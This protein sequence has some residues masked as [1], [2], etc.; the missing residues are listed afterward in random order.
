[1]EKAC[2]SK[3]FSPAD[4]QKLNY[5]QLYLKV[6]TLSG[7][8]N[9]T[10]NSFT[11]G[12]LAGAES[13]SRTLPKVG[14]QSKIVPATQPGPFGGVPS[15]SM[16]TRTACSTL[17]LHGM[18]LAQIS[19]A[20]GRPCTHKNTDRFTD[21]HT[22]TMTPSNPCDMAISPSR[23]MIAMWMSCLTLFLLMRPRPLTAGTALLLCRHFIH[24]KPS[25][26]PICSATRS[27]YFLIMMLCSS[28]T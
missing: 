11:P 20:I 10:W 1:M 4:L 14:L 3:L 22:G 15:T 12:I 18:S 7:V 24:M 19:S 21:A 26:S 27:T 17:L 5:C 23:H 8:T 16:E 9:A 6:T 13:A 2:S 25:L 28:N